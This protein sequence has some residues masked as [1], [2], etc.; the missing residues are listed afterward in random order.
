[1]FFEKY[2]DLFLGDAAGGAAPGNMPGNVTS[3]ERSKTSAF[4]RNGELLA[5]GYGSNNAN[6]QIRDMNLNQIGFKPPVNDFPSFQKPAAPVYPPARTELP[7]RPAQSRENT[8]PTALN[9][10][11]NKP[12]YGQ[13]TYNPVP[14]YNTGPTV[15]QESNMK[16]KDAKT[17][18][19]LRQAFEWNEQPQVD[20]TRRP[21]QQRKTAGPSHEDAQEK[22]FG[23]IDRKDPNEMNV[24]VAN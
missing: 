20:L 21:P 2:K 1:M 8:R 15:R 7:P 24:G 14:S 18:D 4:S 17:S 19:S 6:P 5:G 9:D 22:V 16:A 13:P 12:S 23:Q 10:I 11:V 3:A